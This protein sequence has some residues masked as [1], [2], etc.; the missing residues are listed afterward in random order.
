MS[1]LKQELI[2]VAGCV[3]GA[4]A[5]FVLCYANKSAEKTRYRSEVERPL[6]IM[7]SHIYAVSAEEPQSAATPKLRVLNNG[8]EAFRRGGPRPESFM[9]DVLYSSPSGAN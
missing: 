1:I 2:F 8:Y 3:I 7:A 9:D 4:F 5:G 6:G